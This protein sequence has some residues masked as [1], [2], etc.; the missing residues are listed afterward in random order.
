MDQVQI[1]IVRS[2]LLKGLIQLSFH[3]MCTVVGTPQLQM[4]VNLTQDPSFGYLVKVQDVTRSVPFDKSVCSV[5]T[6]FCGHIL[7]HI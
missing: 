3:F 6:P 2:Q 1:R 7:G 4:L 5:G